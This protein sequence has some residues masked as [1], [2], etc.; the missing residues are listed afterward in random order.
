MNFIKSTAQ[1]EILPPVRTFCFDHFTVEDQIDTRIK[2]RLIEG[3]L[4]AES[5]LFETCVI[6]RGHNVH[7]KCF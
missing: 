4:S 5:P 3:R 1:E 6:G 7:S 2:V